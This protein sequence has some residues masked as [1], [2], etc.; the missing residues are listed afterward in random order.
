M[1]GD[2]IFAVRERRGDGTPAGEVERKTSMPGAGC[3]RIVGLFSTP[4]S[5]RAVQIDLPDG[6]YTDLISGRKV[7]VFEHTIRFTG[8]PVIFFC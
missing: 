1:A 3:D 8:E 5:A 2:V 6:T 7:D 4:G